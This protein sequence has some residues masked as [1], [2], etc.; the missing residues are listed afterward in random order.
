MNRD[1]LSNFWADRPRM[2]DFKEPEPE[3]K[4]AETLCPESLP[5]DL[6]C[7]RLIDLVGN[8]PTPKRINYA[9]YKLVDRY[10]RY[11]HRTSADHRPE[12]NLDRHPCFHKILIEAWDALED[13]E[14]RRGVPELDDPPDP[15]N[16]A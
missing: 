4:E 8:D 7:A 1:E 10:C 14:L 5:F 11:Y 12:H 6:W 13:I 15:G 16:P 3:P 2:F 9:K